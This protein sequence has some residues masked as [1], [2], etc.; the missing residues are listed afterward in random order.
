M[1]TH[2]QWFARGAGVYALLKQ[3]RSSPFPLHHMEPVVSPRSASTCYHSVL[4][5]H[6]SCSVS[7]LLIYF[8][9]TVRNKIFFPH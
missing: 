1:A 3:T 5:S 6:L 9:G 8:I 7:L 4:N 2:I